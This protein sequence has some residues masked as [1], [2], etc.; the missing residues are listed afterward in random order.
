MKCSWVFGLMFLVDSSSSQAD[1]QPS[2]VL[3]K[4]TACANTLWTIKAALG[5]E[6][7][8]ATPKEVALVQA[9]I[10]DMNKVVA[11]SNFKAAV[12]A[13]KFTE[14]NGLTN[15]E[16]YDLILRRSPIRLDVKFYTEFMLVNFFSGNDGFEDRKS[17]NTCFGNRGAI[18]GSRAFLGSLMLHET[19]HVLGFRHDGPVTSTVPY[20]MNRIYDHVAKQLA[21]E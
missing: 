13:A 10:A 9:A 18:K 21:L 8:D 1:Q 19:M 12:L 17:P 15:Q 2:I 14:Q 16:I 7:A 6:L 20:T 3:G 4:I 11:S 5:C